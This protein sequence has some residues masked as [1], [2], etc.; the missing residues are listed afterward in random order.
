MSAREWKAKTCCSPPW[1]SA[2]E[3]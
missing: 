2:F 3:R 1:H